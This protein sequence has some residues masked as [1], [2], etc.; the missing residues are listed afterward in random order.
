MQ[1]LADVRREL[2]GADEDEEYPEEHRERL[3]HYRAHL[4]GP[5]V[6]ASAADRLPEANAGR[7]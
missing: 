6:Y 5:G 2:H 3:E 4:D 7:D 1:V